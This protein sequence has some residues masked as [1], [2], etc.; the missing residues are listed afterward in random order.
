MIDQF[1]RTIDYLRISI[2]DRCNLRCRYCMP[3]SVNWVEHAEVL[4]YEEILQIAA[5]A[6]EIGITHFKVTGGEPLVRKGVVDFIR[7][8]RSLPG[9]KAVTLTTNG[10]LLQQLAQPLADAGLDAVNV[11][12]DAVDEKRYAEITGMDG[13]HQVLQG[14]DAALQAGIQTKINSVLLQDAQ[15]QIVPLARL[16]QQKPVDVRFI[17]LMPIG[18]GTQ[19]G[20]VSPQTARKLLLEQWQDLHPVEEKRGYGPARYEAS[21]QLTGRIGW[22]D[23][24]SHGFCDQCN[25]IRLTS[26]GQLKLCLCYENGIDLRQMLRSG[27]TQQQLQQA[28]QQV[29]VQKPA[30]HCFGTQQEITENRLMAQIGG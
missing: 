26:T 20:G 15:D 3:Q 24:V 29:I 1:N 23:A 4:R 14:I 21:S 10:I 25:R 28:L 13:L 7:Q 19:G 22:I 12:L 18:E 27:A 30:A 5:A 11:S 9:C 16:A 2:T 17:E 8:L 6:I